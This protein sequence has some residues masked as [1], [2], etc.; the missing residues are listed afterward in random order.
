[1]AAMN[2]SLTL[3]PREDSSFIK[4]GLHSYNR[5]RRLDPH[6]LWHRFLGLVR[7]LLF[8]AGLCGIAYYGYGF[9]NEYVYQVYENWAFDQKIAGRQVTFSDYVR[10][11]TPFG[12]LTGGRTAPAKIATSDSLRVQPANA[13]L[14]TE[15]SSLGR[16]QLDRLNLS[17][18]V[19]EGVNDE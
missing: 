4:P 9:S 17:A 18:M 10:E 1:M 3:R 7:G 8:V 11:R 16:V 12:F 2:G 5:T 14:P 15:G 6:P 13:A 19:R